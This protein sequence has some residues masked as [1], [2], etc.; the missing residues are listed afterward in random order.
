MVLRE[1]EIVKFYERF[2]RITRKV[3]D[4]DIEKAQS[5]SDMYVVIKSLAKRCYTLA[6]GYIAAGDKKMAA[7]FLHLAKEYLN[8]ALKYKKEYDLEE[9]AKRIE[10]LEENA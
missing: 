10:K 3:I 7:K 6:E 2:L 5:Y 4:I 1:E 9:L 8:L